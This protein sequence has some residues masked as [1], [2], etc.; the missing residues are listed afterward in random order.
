MISATERLIDATSTTERDPLACQDHVADFGDPGA[1]DGLGAGE[2]ER[3]DAE[4]S[5]DRPGLD[6]AWRINLEGSGSDVAAGDVVP[7]DVFYREDG[8]DLCIAD[9]V[10][11]TF[12]G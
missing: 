3:F 7:T 1:W 10:W 8:D 11:Q 6:A 4:A 5:V 12:E 9:I 2:P